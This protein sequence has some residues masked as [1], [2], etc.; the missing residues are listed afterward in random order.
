MANKQRT[1]TRIETSREREKIRWYVRHIENTARIPY[2]AFDSLLYDSAHCSECPMYYGIN[3]MRC[4]K[5][6]FKEIK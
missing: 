2:C 1:Y 4:A 6:L 5:E 3:V